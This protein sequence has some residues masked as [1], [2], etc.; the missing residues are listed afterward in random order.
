MSASAH[1]LAA[2]APDFAGIAFFMEKPSL[3][4]T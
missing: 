2:Q 4:D 1:S 3:R